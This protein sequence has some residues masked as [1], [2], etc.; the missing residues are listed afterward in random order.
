MTACANKECLPHILMYHLLQAV[1]LDCAAFIQ[2]KS[3]GLG[4]CGLQ[5][6]PFRETDFVKVWQ[7]LSLEQRNLEVTLHPQVTLFN[8]CLT[9]G[10]NGESIS[11]PPPPAA[12]G[13]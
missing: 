11:P 6:L 8:K 2:L 1:T 4:L 7:W 5:L 13:P 10:P 9:V 3:E 12:A